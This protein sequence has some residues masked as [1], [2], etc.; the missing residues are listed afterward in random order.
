MP[1]QYP[2]VRGVGHD[3]ASIVADDRVGE[4]QPVGALRP[5]LE[6]I[7]H[8]TAR[9]PQHHSGGLVGPARWRA[10]T[11]HPMIAG[12][13]DEQGVL[14]AG[15]RVRPAESA[16]TKLTAVVLTGGGIR[17]TKQDVGGFAIAR[18][19]TSPP[20]HPAVPGVRDPEDPSD[21][22]ETERPVQARQLRF[23]APVGLHGVEVH[24]PDDTH[25]FREGCVRDAVEHQQAVVP[26]IR[27]NEV[28]VNDRN[29]GG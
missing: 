26:G 22:S 27:D 18:Q 19:P 21:Q 28:T 2:V 29:A 11:E 10:E 5:V 15:D 9:L 12:I 3:Q 8:L 13:C 14:V 20:Q 7:G 25:G 1:D 24:L 17:L 6:L 23:P 4:T 16:V